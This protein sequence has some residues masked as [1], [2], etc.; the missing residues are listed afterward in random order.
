[1]ALSMLGFGLAYQA[2][3]PGWMA[4]GLLIGFVSLTLTVL[5]IAAARVEASARP[6]TMIMSLE[7]LGHLRRQGKPPVPGAARPPAP[8][9]APRVLPVRPVRPVPPPAARE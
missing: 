2:T 9:G 7:E 5:A 4:I 3:T 6:E 8:A 1:M